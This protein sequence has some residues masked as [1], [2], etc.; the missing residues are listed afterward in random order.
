MKFLKIGLACRPQPTKRPDW[1][2]LIQRVGLINTHARLILCA[3]ALVSGML[4]QA[5]ARAENDPIPPPLVTYKGREIAQTMHYLGAPWLTRESRDREED[6]TTLLQA[7]RIQPGDVVC[8]MGCGNGFYSLRIAPLVGDRGKVVAVDIQRE[9]LEMLK[10]QAAAERITNIE[11]VHGTV[12]D[13]RLPPES[14]DL[15]LM[16]DVYHEFSHPE[17]MLAAIR[18]SLK[19]SGRIALVE[20]RSEDPDVPI[21]PLH[22][23]S[24]AQIM[25]EFPPNGFKLVEEFDKLPWQHLMFFQRDDAVERTRRQGDNDS[26]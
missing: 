20:F 21:K 24:K 1:P 15:M 10:E 8:D 5:Q 9:M 6:C 3:A 13:P 18:K 2:Y 25:K 14:I 11:T 23:M 12:I 19:P 7:L 16:V 4:P 22:K 17:H 26:R